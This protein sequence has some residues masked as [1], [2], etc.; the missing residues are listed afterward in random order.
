MARIYNR[1]TGRVQRL[2]AQ[3]EQ[4]DIQARALIAEVAVQ[5]PELGLRTASMFRRS[6]ELK[7]VEQTAVNALRLKGWSWDDLGELM[8]MSKQAA[9]ERFGRRP[10]QT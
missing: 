1:S 2:S 4:C 5:R 8:L 6:V 3:L 7:A 10:A 9:W